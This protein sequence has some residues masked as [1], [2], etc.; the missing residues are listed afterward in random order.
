MDLHTANHK[1][2]RLL[3]AEKPLWQRPWVSY[4]EL[5]EQFRS[6]DALLQ[7]LESLLGADNVVVRMRLTPEGRDLLLYRV[8]R[9]LAVPSV[10]EPES[11]SVDV[12]DTEFPSNH[13]FEAEPEG[14]VPATIASSTSRRANL[15]R[16]SPNTNMHATHAVERS[17]SAGSGHDL[18]EVF[19][20]FGLC[21]ESISKHT[22]VGAT[23]D[24]YELLPGR[25]TQMAALRRVAED[26][27]RVLGCVGPPTFT[28]IPGSRSVMMD[29]PLPRR[30][31]LPL[32]PVLEK[33]PSTHGLW[34]AMGM[35]PSGELV[36]RNLEA[37]VHILV[38]GA[39]GSGKTR[40][41]M[42]LVIGLA[43]RLSP[44]ELEILLV[45]VKGTDFLGFASLPHLRGGAVLTDPWEAIAA[46]RELLEV[47][48]P[49]RTEILRRAG[50][51]NMVDLREKGGN[52]Y[53]KPVVVII[54]EFA[55]LMC[56]LS[57]S[58]RLEFERDIVRLAQ[59]GRSVAIHLV[60][61]TQRPTTNFVSGAI[62]TNMPTRVAFRLP[63]R[64]DSAV[65]LDRPGAEALLGNGDMLLLHDGQ[66]QRLQSYYV[67]ADDIR[68]LV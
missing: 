56:V 31:P 22:A 45:D 17:V 40:W 32:F 27:G 36:A 55:D 6:R 2:L 10:R 14:G 15:F 20:E 26:V 68:R 1:L 4:K 3:R 13:D 5:L 42:A 61:A 35:A 11:V 28:S 7:A 19:S 47:E 8:P 41:L 39:T 18:K 62:K 30:R 16:V 43:C 48:L 59:R 51:A 25:G 33:L 9:G 57:K 58:E 63:Q 65:I 64:V 23:F 21:L 46:V 66:V 67:D 54:D 12:D 24:R 37:M 34:V 52:V 53:V 50:C 44:L 38:G 60:L 49:A 29:V